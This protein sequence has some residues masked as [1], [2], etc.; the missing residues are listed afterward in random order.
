MHT[1]TFIL[2]H[3]PCRCLLGIYL[4]VQ[5]NVA[6]DLLF[7]CFWLCADCG[8]VARSYVCVYACMHICTTYRRIRCFWLCADCGLVARSYVC[9][10][11]YAYMH[12]RT[13]TDVF[14]YCGCVLTAA[15]LLDPMCVCVCVCVRI[16]TYVQR[17]EAFFCYALRVACSLVAI[18]YQCAY[19]YMHVCTKYRNILL[20]LYTRHVYIYI[21]IYIVYI[22]TQTHI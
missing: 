11:M 3:V 20:F 6:V 16:C 9:V 18:S 12:I 5:V 15:S 8:L 14:F 2:T 7:C 21:Y 10:C 22:Y 4:C 19:A 17:A 1:H 13:R